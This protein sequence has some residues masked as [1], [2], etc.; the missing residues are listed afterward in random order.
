MNHTSTDFPSTSYR[1]IFFRDLVNE[2]GE[3]YRVSI[4]NVEIAHARSRERARE[5][6]LRRFARRHHVKSWDHLADG[7]EEHE[8]PHPW[9]RNA[10]T[11]NPL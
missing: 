8:M 9:G 5:A 2:R 4:D 10:V 7:Y 3:R 6:A 1:V 11:A